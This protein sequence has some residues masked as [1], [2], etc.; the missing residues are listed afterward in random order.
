MS[1]V[2]ETCVRDMFF[3]CDRG[4]VVARGTFARFEVAPIDFGT[5]R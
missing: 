2:R 4:R 1:G 5:I 3:V